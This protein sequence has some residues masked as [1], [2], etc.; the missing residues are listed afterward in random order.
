MLNRFGNSEKNIH[1]LQNLL[2][3]VP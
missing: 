3:T 1:F 2:L